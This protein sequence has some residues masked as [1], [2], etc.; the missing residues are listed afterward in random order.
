MH[1]LSFQRKKDNDVFSQSK[2]QAK[3]ERKLAVQQA[4]R[5]KH[6][7]KKLNNKMQDTLGNIN[8][9]IRFKFCNHI[10]SI[11]KFNYLLI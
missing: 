11:S 9:D 3:K 6:D 10:I 5:K 1:P 8:L 2:H 7:H 4:R